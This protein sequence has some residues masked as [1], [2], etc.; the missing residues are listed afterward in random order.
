MACCLDMFTHQ[1][2]DHLYAQSSAY[3][4]CVIISE[5]GA[6]R[7]MPIFYCPWCGTELQK[8]A[9]RPDGIVYPKPYP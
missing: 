4:P 3:G 2:H 8:K 1:A 6:A 9:D 5:R 7:L